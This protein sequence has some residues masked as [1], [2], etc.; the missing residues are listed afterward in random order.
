VLGYEDVF[1]KIDLCRRHYAG[2]GL[3]EAFVDQ[4]IR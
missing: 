1:T 4:F 2:A 3:G